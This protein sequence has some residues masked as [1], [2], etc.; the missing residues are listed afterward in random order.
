MN[1]ARYVFI[2]C[3]LIISVNLNANTLEKCLASTAY[4]EHRLDKENA[5]NYCFTR[6]KDSTNKKTCFGLVKKFKVLINNQRLLNRSTQVCFYEAGAFSNIKE[7]LKETKRFAYAVDHDDAVFYC[8]QT[9]QDSTN[10]Q[11]CLATAKEMIYF[12][13]RDYLKNH[14]LTQ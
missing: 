10:K 2:F 14:C 9:F 6:Y 3:S 7:C 11:Q 4:H 13:K 8:Y 1:V 12:A 5:V